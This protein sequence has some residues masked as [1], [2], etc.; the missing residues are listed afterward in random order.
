MDA[1]SRL[2]P[3]AMTESSVQFSCSVVSDSAIPW[4]AAHQASLSIT[5]SRSLLKLKSISL[6]MPSEHLILCCPLLFLSSVFP[7]IRV[8]SSEL[9]LRIR[10]PKYWSF[11][12]SLCNEYSGFSS[13]RLERFDLAVQVVEV[14]IFNLDNRIELT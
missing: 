12:I 14:V 13:F 1:R 2:S 8:F 6:M 11:S 4:T 5:N 9:A 7:S 3:L 10:R